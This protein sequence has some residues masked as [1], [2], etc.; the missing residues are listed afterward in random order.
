MS[1]NLKYNG[2]LK[3]LA[4][5]FSIVQA[6]WNDRG[7][8]DKATSIKN[9]PATLKTIEEISANTDENALAGA[10]AVKEVYDSLEG[11]GVCELLAETNSTDTNNTIEISNIKN[12]RYLLFIIL[13]GSN[14]CIC[15]TLIPVDFV[16]SYNK[17]FAKYDNLTNNKTYDAVVKIISDTS[18]NLYVTDSTR[19]ACLYG[20]K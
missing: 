10:N 3:K 15:N 12:F 13:N 8:T 20:I 1:I 11:H 5:N 7:K 19:K 2:I 14:D 18:V 9:Q 6:N 4:N 17:W 16:Y